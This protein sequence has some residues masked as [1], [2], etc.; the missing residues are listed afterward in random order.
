ML[1]VP[2]RLVGV[3]GHDDAPQAAG[4][5]GAHVLL[6]PE[7]AVGANHRVDAPLRR[8]TDHFAQMPVRQRFAADKQHVADMILD[9]NIQHVPRLFQRDAAPLA[10]IEP[11]H[12]E[13][14]EIAF[15]VADV[16]DGKLQIARPAVGENLPGE[17][18]EVLPGLD[19]R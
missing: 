6:R 16:G 7:R 17:L 4:G 19:N 2:G 9:T 8:V 12:G 1:F 10:G 5:Q 14:A 18:P 11:V 13:T 15:G 3:N